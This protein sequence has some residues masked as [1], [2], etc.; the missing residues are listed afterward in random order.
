MPDR[1]SPGVL[2][3]ASIAIASLTG[4]VASA[5]T[6][7]ITYGT[8]GPGAGFAIPDGDP[9]GLSSSIVINDFGTI[10]DL[11]L[12]LNGLSHSFLGD[13]VIT[14]THEDTHTTVVIADRAGINEGG[15]PTFGFNIDLDGGYT[16]DDESTG[17]SFHDQIAFNKGSLPAGDYNSF[18]AL[19]AFDGMSITGT[20]TLFISDNAGSD[21]GELESWSL[22]VET[23]E[24]ACDAAN[25]YGPS[26][27]YQVADSPLSVAIGDLNGDGVPD[28][29]VTNGGSDTVSVLLGNGDGTFQASQDFATG[30]TPRSVAIDDLDGDGNPDLAVANGNFQSVSVL[31]GNGD[32]TYMPAQDFSTETLQN[33]LA[34]GDLNHDGNPDLVVANRFSVYVSVLLGNGDGTFQARQDFGTGNDPRSVAI[35][36]LND[37][38]NPDLAVADSGS[39][40]VSVLLGNGDGTFQ[41]REDYAAGEEPVSVAIGDLNADGNLDLGVANRGSGT[42]SILLGNGNG[43]FQPGQNFTAGL[44]P[45]DLAIGDLNGDG[46]PDLAVARGFYGSVS[47]LPGSGTGAFPVRFDIA[48]GIGSYPGDLSIG[49]V[50]GNGTPDLVTTNLLDDSV[51]VLLNQCGFAAG[52]AIPDGDPAGI[53]S[54][55]VITDVGTITDLDLRLTALTHTWLGDLIITLTHEDTNTTVFI[56]DRAGTSE[57]GFETFGFDIDLGG[58]YI[59]DDESLSGSFHD[60]IAFEEGALPPGDYNSFEALSAFDGLSI[61]G[62]WTLFISDNELPDP[63]LLGSWSL[64][65]EAVDTPPCPADVTGDNAVNLADLN[66]VL[67]KFGQTTP[68]GDTNNDGVV[69]LADLNAVLAAFGQLCP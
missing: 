25:L 13:L 3:L 29:A 11:N 15:D 6:P 66:L 20:W 67:A 51:I 33:D 59:I 8:Y 31:L 24:P 55:L 45:D 1:T 30:D 17:G 50:D 36:D 26:Q 2:G 61:T 49:D 22:L 12:N 41:A 42:V 18:E 16:I 14:L 43:T 27:E 35:G 7:G 58:T 10:N 5:G 53:S 38:G 44:L 56:A 62:T 23:S 54:S 32:G 69:D 21:N 48:T 57:D 19:S 4:A 39:G 37:D 68:D 64:L 34:I 28:L 46:T 47:V 60:Q 52:F 65:A 40:T 9:A 63:G